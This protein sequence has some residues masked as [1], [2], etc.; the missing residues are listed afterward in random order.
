MSHIKTQIRTAAQTVLKQKVT[1][2]SERVFTSRVSPLKTLPALIIFTDIETAQKQSIGWPPRLTR[3]VDMV[4]VARVKSL[5]GV[6][7]NLDQLQLQ[8]EKAFTESVAANN[9]NGLVDSI[10]FESANQIFNVDAEQPVAQVEM[11]FRVEF[12]TMADSPDTPA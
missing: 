12:K 11:H 6:D 3:Q 4:V 9:L 8:T 5:D 2:V 10:T 1:E 7:D